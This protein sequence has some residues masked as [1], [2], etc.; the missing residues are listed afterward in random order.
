MPKVVLRLR[1]L[2]S[3]AESVLELDDADK[4]RAW[5]AARPKFVEGIGIA[6]ELDRDASLALKE[7]MRPLDDEERAARTKLDAARA[8]AE[9]E[10]ERKAQALRLAEK[11]AHRT[12]LLSADSEPTDGDQVELRRWFPSGD[13]RSGR[14]R[15]DAE[16]REAVM[17][18][19]AERNEWVRGRGQMVGEATVVV[20]PGEVPAGQD[21]VRSGRF[22]PVSAVD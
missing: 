1:D 4:A 20:W 19:I 17:A 16:A 15:R 18:W 12:A 8:A 10:R 21:R 9:M 6:S 7:A 13:G 5:L 11:E 3:D 2:K 22:T 14:A